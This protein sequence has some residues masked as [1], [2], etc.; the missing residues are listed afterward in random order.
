MKKILFLNG[1]PRKKGNTSTLINLLQLKLNTSTFQTD[2]EFLYNYEIK[3]C[4]DCRGCKKGTLE[5]VLKDDMPV[6]YTK[7]NAADY[8]VFGTPIYWFGPTAKMK[9]LIDRFRPYYANKNLKNKK[10]I[11]LFAAGSGEEDTDLTLEMYRRVF[12]ALEMTFI[13][14]LSTKAYDENDVYEDD[15]AIYGIEKLA[16]LL[17]NSSN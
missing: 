16:E 10:G 5:C 17:N 6:I 9:L 11:L 2:L 12:S 15:N 1:S 3:P 13:T 8:L 14:S 7:I 4:V